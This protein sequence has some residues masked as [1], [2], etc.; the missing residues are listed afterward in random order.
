MRPECLRETGE[1]ASGG[2]RRLPCV[3]AGDGA[4]SE[5]GC[6]SRQL[7]TVAS[8]AELPP[9]SRPKRPRKDLQELR[10][11]LQEFASPLF[12]SPYDWIVLIIVAAFVSSS[13]SQIYRGVLVSD[14][15]YSSVHLFSIFG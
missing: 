12:Q 8:V 7:A 5:G 6:R 15:S 11:D 14:A 1:E 2:S 9:L 13:D 3:F 10:K 4:E